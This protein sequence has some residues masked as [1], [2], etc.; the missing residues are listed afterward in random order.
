MRGT[1]LILEN[2]EENAS[3]DENLEMEGENENKTGK[4]ISFKYEFLPDFCYTCG[5]I[6]HNYRV[7][8]IK[9]ARGEKQ[10]FGEWLRADVP[11]KSSSDE[12][13]L[14]GPVEKGDFWRSNSD[15]SGGSKQGSD[16]I[17]WRKNVIEAGGSKLNDGNGKEF[18]SSLKIKQ[19]DT[20]E[21]MG[22]N[23]LNLEEKFRY[24]GNNKVNTKG[25]IDPKWNPPVSDSAPMQVEGKNKT[26]VYNEKHISW[27]RRR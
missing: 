26:T 7:C 2:E 22:G 9:L 13:R 4:M 17:S 6:G 11:R 18:T 8:S 12:E 5:I 27:K 16:A 24:S 25:D 21:S 3:E 15:G 10:Q 1:S 20:S 23:K 19:G 14:R